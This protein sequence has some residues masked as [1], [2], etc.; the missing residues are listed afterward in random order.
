M[1]DSDVHHNL[2]FGTVM[3]I[4]HSF[5]FKKS[6]NDFSPFPVAISGREEENCYKGR[7]WVGIWVSDFHL[8]LR[9]IVHGTHTD[10]FSMYL[11]H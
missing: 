2:L 1:R 5:P 7:F 6:A 9:T 8:G 4:D 11:C 10:Q 3:L